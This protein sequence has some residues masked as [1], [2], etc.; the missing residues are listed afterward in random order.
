MSYTLPNGKEVISEV[1]MKLDESDLPNLP[2]ACKVCPAAMWQ[3]TGTIAKPSVRCYCRAMHT[4]TWDN[5][6]QEEI[7]DCDMIYQ[8]DEEDETLANTTSTSMPAFMASQASP[9]SPN[10]ADTDYEEASED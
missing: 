9:V 7:L 3:L 2:M 1:L 5:K 10:D 4:F 6:T 8:E